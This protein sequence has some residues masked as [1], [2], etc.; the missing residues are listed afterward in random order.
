MGWPLVSFFHLGTLSQFPQYG[1][2]LDVVPETFIHFWFFLAG[3]LQL[4]GLLRSNFRFRFL[5]AMGL[6][7][8]FTLIVGGV[9]I[10]PEP[11]PPS[12]GPYAAC[13]FI[14]FCA[15]VF[16]TGVVVRRSRGIPR[17]ISKR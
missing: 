16:L 3:L 2:I 6:L 4:I 5:G 10:A 11:K 15:V 13:M 12:L 8:G 7:L 17:W 9:L 1:V 14:E